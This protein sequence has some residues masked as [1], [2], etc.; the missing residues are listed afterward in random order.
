M[1]MLLKRLFENLFFITGTAKSLEPGFLKK[2]PATNTD[3]ARYFRALYT[4]FLGVQTIILIFFLNISPLNA[5]SLLTYD[6]DE[7]PTMEML[8]EAR[9]VFEYEVSYGFFTLGWVDVE[10]RPDTTYNEKEVYHLRTTI[11]SNRRVPF[12]GTRIV[13]YENLFSYNRFFPYSYVFWRDDIHDEE[14]EVV[15]VEFD[16]DHDEVRFYE[17]GE[18]QNSLDLVEP[19]SGGD[20]IFYYSRLFAGLEDPYRKP[21]FIEGEMGMVA[22]SSSPKTE[23]RKYDAF[24]NPIETYLSEG[25]ADVDGPFGFRGDF[26]SW[27]S[28]DDLRVPVEAHVRVIFGNVKVRLISYERHN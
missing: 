14:Y 13:N 4:P 23:M 5:Q 22:A 27:F 3:W 8:L 19:S 6:R 28:T 10:L 12:V 15:K 11:R 18:F 7:P 9:E 1:R 17:K 21:A 16:R 26:K 2:Y 24:E 25:S 20:L